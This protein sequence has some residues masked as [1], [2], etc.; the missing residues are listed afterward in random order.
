MRDALSQFRIHA[1]QQQNDPALRE[2]VIQ[3]IPEPAVALARRLG[4]HARLRRDMLLARPFPDAQGP[5]QPHPFQLAQPV[6]TVP[7]WWT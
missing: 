6:S 5:W 4:L 2:P 3:A 7:R 1:S